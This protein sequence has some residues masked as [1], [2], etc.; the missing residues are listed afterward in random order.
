M[1][2]S[3][4]RDQPKTKLMRGE[5]IQRFVL[6]VS[7]RGILHQEDGKYSP[8]WLAKQEQDAGAESSMGL[9]KGELS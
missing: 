5:K 6:V 3:L 2:K 7:S 1:T 4:V 8:R 9:Q